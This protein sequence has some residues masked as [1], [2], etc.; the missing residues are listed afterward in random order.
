MSLDCPRC[1]GPADDVPVDPRAV[2]NCPWCGTQYER[3]TAESALASLREEI[4]EWLQ[5]TTGVSGVEGADAVDAAT[6]SFLFNDRMLPRLRRDVLR[7]L[8]EGIGDVLGAPILVPPALRAMPGFSGEDCVLLSMRENIL[9]LRGQRARLESKE[10]AG[11]ATSPADRIALDKLRRDIDRAVLA[12][13]ASV[14]IATEGLVS[15]AARAKQNI[16]KLRETAKTTAVE[17]TTA[18]A[19]AALNHAFEVRCECLLQALNALTEEPMD[20]AALQASGERLEAT[21]DWLLAVEERDLRGAL[22][23]TGLH[24]DATA[25]LMLGAVAQ[26]ARETR[27]P[28]MRLMEELHAASDLLANATRSADAIALVRAWALVVASIR[29]GAVLPAVQD[30][31]W[32]GKA[33]EQ[34]ART[35]EKTSS[36]DVV[37]TPYW[38]MTAR[39]AKAEGFIFKSGK[40]YDGLALVPGS[41]DE[42]GTL[43]LSHQDH[44]ARWV[45]H[46]LSA[47]SEVKQ[48][49]DVPWVGPGAA[50]DAA[51]RVLRAKDLRNVSLG[52]PK[53][54][55]VPVA[56]ARFDG[57]Q[58]QRT[59]AF[60]LM[61]PVPHDPSHMAGRVGVMRRIA[62]LLG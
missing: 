32:V 58:G 2:V 16:E 44:L 25:L 21:S 19:E 11:F 42:S 33:A 36:V 13:N 53:L 30:V 6:R 61:G 59:S 4:A 3:Q 38:V 7:A 22:A 57:P 1:G 43:M 40:Q 28:P 39:H 60:A 12:S 47:P 31:S 26:V 15:G 14:A 37:F 46:A 34:Q 48:Q 54:V 20:V 17:Q 56:V 27:L 50:C 8:D 10:V 49:V 9:E 51:R 62:S 45:Q 5:S 55:Y 35:G 24:R 41:T 18:P 23:S 52:E 29:L